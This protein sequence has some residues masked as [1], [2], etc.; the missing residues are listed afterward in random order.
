MA[1][2]RLRRV[3]RAFHTSPMP[4]VPRAERI[5]YG[6]SRVPGARAMDLVWSID[7]YGKT[8]VAAYLQPQR[9]SARMIPTEPIGSIPRPAVLLDA[10]ERH[11]ADDPALDALYTDAIRDTVEQFEATGSPVITDGEQRK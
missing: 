8:R 9:R 7:S 6:P 4:P 11:D 5:S 10:L 2:S 1:T 3:S